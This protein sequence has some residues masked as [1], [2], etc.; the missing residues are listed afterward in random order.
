MWFSTQTHRVS[1]CVTVLSISFNNGNKLCSGYWEWGTESYYRLYHR[2]IL[3]MQ[4]KCHVFFQMLIN[5]HRKC[6][7]SLCHLN[8]AD[9]SFVNFIKVWI[10]TVCVVKVCSIQQI[11]VKLSIRSHGSVSF[12]SFFVFFPLGCAVLFCFGIFKLVLFCCDS[13]SY[14]HIAQFLQHTLVNVLS[15]KSPECTTTNK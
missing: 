15:N 4:E 7:L 5:R 9:L 2:K 11:W 1:V 13:H 12:W 3:F 10:A 14:I 8:K 6:Y